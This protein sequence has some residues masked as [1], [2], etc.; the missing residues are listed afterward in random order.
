MK[1]RATQK[2]RCVQKAFKTRCVQKA[3]LSVSRLALSRAPVR[4]SSS[5]PANLP[6]SAARATVSSLLMQH[7]PPVVPRDSPPSAGLLARFGGEDEVIPRLMEHVKPT[8]ERSAKTVHPNADKLVQEGAADSYA[9]SFGA[10]F[11]EQSDNGLALFW[12]EEQRLRPTSEH[13]HL[14][15]AMLT[16]ATAYQDDAHRRHDAR[17]GALSGSLVAS[18]D[19]CSIRCILGLFPMLPS[20]ATPSIFSCGP[21]TLR[22]VLSSLRR[23]SSAA[24]GWSFRPA[25]GFTLL[26]TRRLTRATIRWKRPKWWPK[27]CASGILT[28]MMGGGA[29]L[30]RWTPNL[31]PLMPT[32]KE[33][34]LGRDSSRRCTPQSP[35]LLAP[36]ILPC[37][38][39]LLLELKPVPT[40]TAT[41]PTTLSLTRPHSRRTLSPRVV[42]PQS[43]SMQSLDSLCDLSKRGRCHRSRWLNEHRQDYAT[44]E[45]PTAYLSEQCMALCKVVI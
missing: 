36:T 7:A 39:H 2:T 25:I 30:L 4:I 11:A 19:T 8:L 12:K 44:R 42:P 22:S 43:H 21:S 28:S 3:C 6:T 27:R 38:A 29:L 37:V 9:R 18:S 26:A 31:G 17:T 23:T 40:P 41:T 24:S 45:C 35:H 15:P 32:S 1:R 13:Y 14:A 20:C 5:L 34:P 10:G 33:Q 16:R